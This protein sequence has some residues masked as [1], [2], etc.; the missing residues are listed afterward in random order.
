M[1]KHRDKWRDGAAWVLIAVALLFLAWQVGR[2]Y[3]QHEADP[4]PLEVRVTVAPI[5]GD[6]EVVCMPVADWQA[7]R[8]EVTE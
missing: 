2:A 4:A 5:D 8:E 1:I 6:D 7:L 3:G